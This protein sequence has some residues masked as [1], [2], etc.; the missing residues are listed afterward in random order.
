M[1]SIAAGTLDAPTGLK[2]VLQIY[3]DHAGDYYEI[4]PRIPQRAD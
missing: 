1:T 2:T 3:V 4:D